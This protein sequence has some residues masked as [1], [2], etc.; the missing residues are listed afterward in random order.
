M[1]KIPTES[2]DIKG[3]EGEDYPPYKVSQPCSV[4]GCRRPVD[5]TH[6]IV[7]RSF[8]GGPFDW[9]RM[10]DGC[11]IGNLT[12]MCYLHHEDV[13]V[14]K[15]DVTYDDGVYFWGTDPL[16]PQPPRIQNTAVGLG[17]VITEEHERETCPTCKRKMPK[18][19]IETDPEQKKIR[20]TWAISIPVDE[21][22]N[23]YV[24]LD[25]LLEAARDKLDD[26]GISY[27][28][29]RTARYHILTATLGI[30]V[31]NAEVILADG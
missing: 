28:T 19:K 14:N 20:A 9:V 16:D 29:A 21:Q 27:S 10:P 1:T 24:V 18:P 26:A 22:E 11:E 15:K 8:L 4:P 3:L 13:T 6:H 25:E 23:G 17:H 2:W 5:H 31:Q 12:G 30:F 7:R